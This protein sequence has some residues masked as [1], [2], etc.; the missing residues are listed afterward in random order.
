MQ[1][2][3]RKLMVFGK[4]ESMCIPG[5][6]TLA[7]L[8][9]IELWQAKQDGRDGA[10]LAKLVKR[11]QTKDQAVL[12]DVYERAI[13]LPVD[14]KFPFTEPNDLESIRKLRPRVKS[15]RFDVP[16]NEKWLFDRLYGAWL[17]RCAGCTLGGPGEGFRPDTRAKLIKYLTGKSASEWPINNYMPESS[18]SGITFC[19]KHDA[20]RERLQYTPA[21]DDLTHTM[22][23]QIALRGLNHPAA[24]QTKDLASVW[25]RYVP[26]TVMEGGTGMLALRNLI[27]RY[28]MQMVRFKIWEDSA[29]DWNWTATHNNPYREDIDAAIRADSYGYAAP[30]MP[31]L[32]AELAWKD[33]RISNVKNGI[34]C[35]MFYAAMVAAAFALD[36]PL[37]IVEAGLAEI[38]ATSR[39]YD[40]A[41]KTVDICKKHQFRP[42][43][44]EQAIE[45]IYKTF[46]DDHNGTP[47]N[48]AAVLVGVL[49]GGRDF[50]KVIAYTVMTGWDCDSTAATSGSIAGA[51]LGAKKIPT[52]WTKPF[53]DTVYGQIVGY[54]PIAISEC[55]RRSVEIAAKMLDYVEIKSKK[56]DF[57]LPRHCT[58]F[59]PIDR[60][61]PALGKAKLAN[62]PKTLKLSGQ[63]LKGQQ[64]KFDAKGL[65]NLAS[66][67][68]ATGPEAEGVGAYV[69]IPFKAGREQ[70]IML[71]F[72]ADWWFTAYLD[73]KQI[74][75][76]EPGGNGASP[77]KADQFLSPPLIIT[78][79]SHLLTIRFRSG[80]GGS[81]L[82]V[83]GPKDLQKCFNLHSV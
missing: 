53:N 32:A 28:P 76:S 25:L 50:E 30:G 47:N 66:I 70:K 49:M 61:E 42:E 24:F 22:I 56:N 60:N 46:G 31:E 36:D 41:R 67:I 74:A 77:P 45:D 71:G 18:P 43:R 38:P 68:G 62:L 14:P 10:K 4:E 17:G 33:A 16:N 35:S 39:L 29:Y 13:N 15:R 26:Y 21:D 9:M 34:Y 83:G 40:A 55:A 7:G 20:T 19:I 69:Y 82:A 64:M 44:I 65:L 51:M 12:L 79:G 57:K 58:V 80:Q 23:A 27:L 37:Q 11:S 3:G 81:L 2:E 6:D 59:G 5:G 63:T 72:G 73:G 54:H 52:K 75:T 48:M 1:R 8:V 78:K